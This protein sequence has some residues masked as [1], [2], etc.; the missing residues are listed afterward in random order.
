MPQKTIWKKIKYSPILIYIRLVKEG[1]KKGK[2]AKWLMSVDFEELYDLPTI[3]VKK[4][5]NITPSVYWISVKPF[6][7]KLHKHYKQ[8]KKEK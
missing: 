6:W 2:K 4:L 5:L 8:L 3:N 1:Y 7:T